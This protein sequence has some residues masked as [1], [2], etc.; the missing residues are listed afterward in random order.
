M[1]QGKALEAASKYFA[2]GNGMYLKILYA[3][4]RV[5]TAGRRELTGGQLQVV[6]MV[7]RPV[8]CRPRVETPLMKTSSL[9][10]RHGNLSTTNTV[11]QKRV[12]L[13]WIVDSSESLHQRLWSFLLAVSKSALGREGPKSSI[14]WT[15]KVSK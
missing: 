3:S 8:R 10:E 15:I 4:P 14:S 7:L 13:D 2:V 9:S 5:P 6:E 11:E 12:F 1:G